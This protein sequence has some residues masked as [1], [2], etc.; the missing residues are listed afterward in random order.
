MGQR[1]EMIDVREAVHLALTQ[2][3]DITDDF[4]LRLE[5]VTI[6]AV[7]GSRMSGAMVRPP[8]DGPHPTMLM[9]HGYPGLVNN[10]DLTMA[11]AR[12]G[13]NALT[14]HYR[15]LWGSGGAFS[16]GN[17]IEDA[18]SAFDFVTSP[19]NMTRHAIDPAC[20][21]LAGHSLG[22]FLALR[23]ASYAAGRIKGVAV[24][25]G[26]NLSA[27][28]AMTLT[29]EGYEAVMQ[30]GRTQAP[31]AGT[32]IEALME[33]LQRHHKEWDFLDD[34]PALHAASLLVVAANDVFQA[35]NQRLVQRLIDT[36]NARVT[37][38]F[39]ETDHDF[40]SGRIRLTIELLT[41]LYTLR[42]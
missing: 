22:G 8:G 26:A 9:F 5:E 14:F 17:A 12:L 41:W 16:W 42:T 13:W 24:L 21:V 19:E 18:R 31:V 3:P 40:S 32:T 28:G 27:L 15:G 37:E 33:E 23:T 34:A 2:D 7:D 30:M 38:R 20:I 10:R 35:E 29:P 1:H 25:S 4:P 6:T 39:I 11:V 36:G